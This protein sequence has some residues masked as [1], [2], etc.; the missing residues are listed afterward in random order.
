MIK[1]DISKYLRLLA[2]RYEI[3]LTPFRVVLFS[4][5]PG[6]YAEDAACI[7]PQQSVHFTTETNHC[8]S[9]KQV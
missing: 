4:F 6:I 7:T 1:R 8:I 2:L 9:N 5:R 3:K